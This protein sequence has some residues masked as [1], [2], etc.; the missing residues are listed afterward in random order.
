MDR[1]AAMRGFVRIVERRSFTRAAADLG[2]SPAMATLLVQQLEAHLGVTL[3]HRTTRR[4]SPTLD[5]AAYY[6][7]CVRWLAELDDIEDAFSQRRRQPRGR[8]RIDLPSSLGRVLVM[9]ALPD[10]CQ[11]YP[12]LELVISADD[13]PVDVIGEGIDCVLRGGP[14]HDEGLAVR[15]L[16]AL[17]QITCASPDYLE[18]Q[19]LPDG[20]DDLS[21]HQLVH[22]RSLRSGRRLPFEFCQAGEIRRLE[23]GGRLAV[24]GADL[25]VGAAL[26]GLGL[27]QAPLY[28]LAAHLAAGRLCE[29]LP[30]QRPPGLPLAAVYPLASQ[31]SPRV[32][33]WVEW[34]DEVFAAVEPAWLRR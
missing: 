16:G 21:E 17:V 14:V 30:E 6:E 22:Y 5:G 7:R 13:R 11:R 15:S 29:V 12:D 4:V 27:I 19:G 26:A 18:R 8:L 10:F 9:P 24:S 25:Y 3:L 34:L 28:H 32:R 2:L 33:A 20:L 31:T 23:P 1:L